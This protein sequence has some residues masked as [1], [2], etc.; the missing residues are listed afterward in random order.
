MMAALD[1]LSVLNLLDVQAI[2]V[3]L[4]GGWGVD[5]LFGEQTREHDDLDL[6]IDA[7]RVGEAQQLLEAVGFAVERDWLPTALALRDANGRA[8]D[9]HPVALTADGGGDQTLLDGALFH[10]GPPAPGCVDGQV[11]RCVALETQLLC[12]LGY[13]PDDDDRADMRRLAE[14]FGVALPP[15]YAC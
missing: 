10:Y 12:H 7:T 1:V 9:L 3:W 13:E 8:I 6:V 15:P 2:E 14:R 11:V 4:D 5:A